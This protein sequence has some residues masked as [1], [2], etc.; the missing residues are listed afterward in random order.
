ML[1]GKRLHGLAVIV[2]IAMAVHSAISYP[3]LRDDSYIES[4]L[5]DNLDNLLI[6]N[7][8]QQ[9][10]QEEA[11]NVVSK[12]WPSTKFSHLCTNAFLV[13]YVHSWRIPYV[14]HFRL[15]RI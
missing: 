10:A 3:A 9:Q 14:F 6:P 15:T 1:P 11:D 8:I 12:R 13:Y 5:D 7:G 4:D 2:M